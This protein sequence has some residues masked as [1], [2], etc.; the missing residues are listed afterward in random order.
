MNI[1]LLR[2]L[3][4]LYY[5]VWVDAITAVQKKYPNPIEYLL[6]S[7]LYI[8]FCSSIFLA[9]II[10]FLTT[11]FGPFYHLVEV[12]IPHLRILNYPIS[13]FISFML[14]ISLVNYFLIFHKN[15]YKIL[16]KIYPSQNGIAA[17]IFTLITLITPLIYVGLLVLF[18]NK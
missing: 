2:K 5:I 7:F 8:N 18:Q 15:K 11:I 12:N 1:R 17:I 3:K 4:R 16:I 9:Y 10:V 13:F 14:P 6:Y